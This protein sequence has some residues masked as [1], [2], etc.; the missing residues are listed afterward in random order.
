VVVFAVFILAWAVDGLN[1]YLTFFPQLPYLYEPHNL[2]RLVTGTLQGL[3]IAAFLLPVLN[4]ALW[5]DPAP[6][7]SVGGWHDLA[8]MSVGGAVVVGLVVSEWAVLLYP[9]TLISGLTVV[10]LI[11]LVNSMVALVLLR[12]EGRA[13]RWQEAAAPL[14]VG[15]VMALVELG[16]IGVLRSFL[17]ERLELP[18]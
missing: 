12:R 16:A 4:L 17:T 5:A 8:W 9:L 3:A 14:L 7:P 6:K 1:S 10:V 18:F 2:L 15:V 13:R 11:G